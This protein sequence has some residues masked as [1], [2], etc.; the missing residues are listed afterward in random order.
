MHTLNNLLGIFRC[1]CG[2][3][4]IA[5][6]LHMGTVA[7]VGREFDMIIENKKEPL[8]NLSYLENVTC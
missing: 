8:P 5:L 4:R 3:F 2:R 7:S 1:G 6:A